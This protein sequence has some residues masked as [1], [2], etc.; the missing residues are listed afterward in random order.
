[1]GNSKVPVGF[2]YYNLFSSCEI[3]KNEQSAFAIAE[4]TDNNQRQDRDKQ[5]RN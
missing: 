2:R 4:T 1:M 5:T 3:P